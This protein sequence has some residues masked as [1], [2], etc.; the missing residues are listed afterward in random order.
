MLKLGPL[1]IYLGDQ[2]VIDVELEMVAV[3]THNGLGKSNRF[4]ATC[5][6]KGRLEHDYFGRITL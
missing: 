3:R 6:M 1:W 5:P 2:L 4:I